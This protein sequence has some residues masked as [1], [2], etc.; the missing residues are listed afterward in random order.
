MRFALLSAVAV[1]LGGHSA[2]A[3]QLNGKVLAQ[4]WPS[5]YR[6]SLARMRGADSDP[7][8]VRLVEPVAGAIPLERDQHRLLFRDRDVCQRTRHHQRC[9][10]DAHVCI[11]GSGP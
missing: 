6:L 8:S 10:R 3:A 5:T 2:T 1:L 7:F 11:P 4:Y 9:Q